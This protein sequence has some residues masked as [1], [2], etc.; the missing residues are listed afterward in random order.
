MPFRLSG[1]F[2]GVVGFEDQKLSKAGFWK[3]AYDL[4]RPLS[5]PQWPSDVY[6]STSPFI[7][8]RRSW[9]LRHW[10]Q[11]CRNW[12]KDHPLII[13]RP[14]Q[15][16]KFSWFHS[17]SLQEYLSY[18]FRFLYKNMFCL[19]SQA[20]FSIGLLVSFFHFFWWFFILNINFRG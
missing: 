20:F 3:S 15:A 2:V 7:H 16:L 11:L 14:T 18:H 4:F 5:V 1:N 9:L 12:S 8:L 19:V 10:P 13:F 6:P 17:F